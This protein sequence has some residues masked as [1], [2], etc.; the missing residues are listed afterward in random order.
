MK[1]A[2]YYSN[3]DIRLEDYP[4][5]EI[6]EDEALV[7][8]KSC[9]ICGTDVLEWYR[10]K[11]APCVL[12]HE[13]AGEI[14]RVGKNVQGFK[15]GNRVF[16]SHHV[17]CYKCDYC[18]RGDFTAC[19]FLHKSNYEPGGFAEYIRIPEEN[20]KYGT[21]LLPDNVSYQTATMIE[22][23]A[24]A[25][26][27]QRQI[28]I[29]SNQ[30]VMVIGCGVSGILHIYL[31]KQKKAKVIAI[32]IN[33]FKLQKAMEFGAD[34]VFNIKTYPIETLREINNGR[35]VERVIV[36]ASADK[37]VENALSSI[38]KKGKILFFATPKGDIKLPSVK[39]WRDELTIT[40][41][42]GAHPLDI[43]ESLNLIATGQIQA[44]KMITNSVSLS[45]IQKGFALVSE[46]TNCLKVPVISD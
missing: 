29:I 36:C 3:S 26:S 17:P 40:S 7:K 21:F 28:D 5:P 18:N 31:A 30:T 16:V 39:I 27:G 25:I 1:V 45:N 9:G 15:I 10:Q 38:D 22:P 19:D 13:M 44:D 11:K 24:C 34:C 41:S 33:D 12:G 43:K 14:V 37:V 35:L 4:I 23:L 2:V 20:L 46:S 8:M 6:S 42:Y 32:D